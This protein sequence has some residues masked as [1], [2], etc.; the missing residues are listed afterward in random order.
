MN[1]HVKSPIHFF[2]AGL[3]LALLLALM[4]VPVAYAQRTQLKPGRW[5]LFS[6][7]QDVELG[8]QV[9][10]DAE[11]KL[12]MLNNRRVDDYLDRLGKKLAAYAMGEKY[13]YQFKA[14]NDSSINAFALPG[15]FIFVN[16]GTIEAA[17]DEA[18]LAGVMAHEIGH[19]ALRHG[20]NQATKSYALQA[21]GALLGGLLGSKSVGAVVAQIGTGFAMN[22][23]L[24]KYSRDD[25]RQSDLIGTQILYDANYDPNAMALFFDKLDT[26]ESGVDFFSSHPNPEN[27]I[28]NINAE[29]RRLGAV[30]NQAVSGRNEFRSVQRLVKSLPAAPK[31]A[32]DQTETS[33]SG[34]SKKPPRPSNR[35][36]SFDSGYVSLRYPDNW[37]SHGGEN[38]FSL[39]PEGGIIG[40]ENDQAMAYGAM[41][42]VY[43]PRSGNRSRSDLKQA[44]DQL[45]EGL[46]NSNP[47][48]RITKGQEQIRFGNQT[49]LSTIFKND[50]PL[51]GSE[52]DWLVTVL[53]PEGLAYF[54]FVAPER[55]FDD[56]QQAFEQILDSVTF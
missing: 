29:I 22:S 6:P 56:Y 55:D 5:N 2:I 33:G 38:D 19:V 35:L 44:T 41:M 11:K 4:P 17:D 32:A 24:L 53:R 45:I 15:G 42:A 12:A 30:S 50:S 9:A 34:Q 49:A 31:K 46:Q 13:P 36:R 47:K 48:M 43:A 54:V 28:Q 7:Q 10:Q 14:V 16:R 37:K 1:R 8:Q 20:T 3:A 40:D 18:E 51:G 27:R 26:R 23:V 39:A 25:E 52:I 21:P